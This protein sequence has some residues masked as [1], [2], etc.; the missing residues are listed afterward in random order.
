VRQVL[1]DDSD[2]VSA[3]AHAPGRRLGGLPHLVS[4]V[5]VDQFHRDQTLSFVEGEAFA[6]NAAVQRAEVQMLTVR[7]AQEDEGRMQV[8]GV[9]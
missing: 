2:G 9:A 4:R 8:A 3:A 7:K 5:L 6:A 1:F